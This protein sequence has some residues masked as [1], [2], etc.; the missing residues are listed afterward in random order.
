MKGTLYQKLKAVDGINPDAY[1]A[2]TVN[3]TG[4]DTK[5]FREL[6]AILQIGDMETS[7]TLAVKLQDSNDDGSSDAY[8][9]ITSAAFAAKADATDDNTISTLHV[10]LD[11]VKRYVRVVAVTGV[12][13]VDHGVAIILGSAHREP[14]TQS[15]TAVSVP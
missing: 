5:G 6:L 2:A 14:V 8:A 10:N 7:A 9:D 15:V 4:F 13:A 11:K 12:D 3:G 1:G